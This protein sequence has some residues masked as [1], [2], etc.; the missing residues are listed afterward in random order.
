LSP[1]QHKTL[2]QNTSRKTIQNNKEHTTDSEYNKNKK[3]KRET[4]W[5]ESAS[6]LLVYLPS[7]R[8]LSAKL[9]PTFA[10]RLCHVVSMTDMKSCSLTDIHRYFGQKALQFLRGKIKSNIKMI[11]KL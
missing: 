4:P 8:R 5:P 6:K 10:D 11:Y 9:V 3:N 2:K 1:N 7:D